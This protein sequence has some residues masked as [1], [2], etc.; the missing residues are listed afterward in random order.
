MCTISVRY[1]NFRV[2][3]GVDVE[4]AQSI[5]KWE[6]FATKHVQNITTESHSRVW[7]KAEFSEILFDIKNVKYATLLRRKHH[8]PK[9]LDLTIDLS[10]IQICHP[11]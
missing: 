7:N 3:G 4:N 11:W 2:L 1:T 9:T 6:L 8:K 5:V 10:G